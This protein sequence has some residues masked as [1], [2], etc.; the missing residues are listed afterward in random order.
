MSRTS[1]IVK[2]LQEQFPELTRKQAEIVAALLLEQVASAV[3]RGGK[4][5]VLPP[6]Q[7][8]AFADAIMEVDIPEELRA[9][10][11]DAMFDPR[12]NVLEAAL[13]EV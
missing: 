4:F 3:E 2:A 5:V 8:Q 7:M 12:S 11:V 9:K 1:P 6:G 13:A 10:L